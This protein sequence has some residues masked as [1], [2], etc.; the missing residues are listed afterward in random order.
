M[1]HIK[2]KKFVED[3]PDLEIKTEGA[4]GVDLYCAE[5]VLVKPQEVTLVRLGVGFDYPDGYMGILATRSSLPLKK[6]VFIANG[7]GIIDTDYRGEHMIQL[8]ALKEP[9]LFKKG[10]RIAQV[11]FTPVLQ[12]YG[13]PIVMTETDALSETERN[14]GSFGSTGHH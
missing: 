14:E 10:E 3:L 5:D 11:V 4:V 8:V 12:S 6:G 7:V 13:D 2:Y 1:P 9:V